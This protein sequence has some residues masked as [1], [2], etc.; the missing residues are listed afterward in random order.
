MRYRAE[1]SF[2]SL[3][4]LNLK[5]LD[6]HGQPLCGSASRVQ[7]DAVERVEAVSQ[8]CHPCEMRDH[9]FEQ[10]ETFLFEIDIE[11]YEPRDISPGASQVGD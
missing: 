5:S 1:R 7:I 3:A 8:H 6:D 4:A 9:L 2:H 11:R 10:L